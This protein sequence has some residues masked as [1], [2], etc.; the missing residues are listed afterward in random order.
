[1]A[2]AVV[3]P[4]V[5]RYV[6]KCI[7]QRD[8][9]LGIL[10]VV[11]R[12]HQ[13]LHVVTRTQWT[14]EDLAYLGRGWCI[15]PDTRV[16]GLGRQNRTLGG[17]RERRGER[18]GNLLVWNVWLGSGDHDEAGAGRRRRAVCPLDELHLVH[19]RQR[20]VGP[21]CRRRIAWACEPHGQL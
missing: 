10:E 12:R 11:D 15:L 7:Y 8:L 4:R 2:D 21:G 6:A 3:M 20:C 5:R 14:G 9:A 13:V 16:T 18:Q 17:D 19:D 1:L